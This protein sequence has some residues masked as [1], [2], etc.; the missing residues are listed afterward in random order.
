MHDFTGEFVASAGSAPAP[1]VTPPDFHFVVLNPGV[2]L[3]LGGVKASVPIHIH[4][5]IERHPVSLDVAVASC[6]AGWMILKMRLR[7]RNG[8]QDELPLGNRQP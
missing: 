6:D 3:P 2:A 4:A 5:P 8:L 7:V 1:I